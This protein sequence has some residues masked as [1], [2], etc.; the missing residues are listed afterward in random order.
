MS[1]VKLGENEYTHEE[2]L[3]RAVRF[4]RPQR[5]GIDPRWVTVRNSFGLGSTSARALCREYGLD[6]E[7]IV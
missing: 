3:R 7:E 2:L 1:T 6:P 5:P 4:M